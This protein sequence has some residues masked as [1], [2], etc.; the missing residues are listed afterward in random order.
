MENVMKIVLLGAAVLLTIGVIVV[1][2]VLYSSGQEVVKQSEQD[3]AGLSQTL[4]MKKFEN[5]NNTIVS[6][7]QV[8]NA[9]RMYTETEPITVSVKTGVSS[10][11]VVYS[12]TVK[13]SETDM[14]SPSYINPIG[15]FSSAL[16]V[17]ESKLVTNITFIQ[18]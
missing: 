7:S 5:F 14:K 15:Q 4:S 18:K 16:T 3:L 10:A 1:G 9:I 13:Y 11:T 12:K 2:V 17:N 6:G 8:I